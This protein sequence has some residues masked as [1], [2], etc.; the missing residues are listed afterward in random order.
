[1]N[2]KF[3]SVCLYLFQ[4]LWTAPLPSSALLV[5]TY[6]ILDD[7][8]IQN[9]LYSYVNADVLCWQHRRAKIVDRIKA[10]EPDVVCLQELN[11][12]SFEFF[13][14]A[15]EGFEGI[16][17]KKGGSSSHGIGTFCKTH[18]FKGISH[19][20][21]AREGSCVCSTVPLE[22]TLFTTLFLENDRSIT[23]VNTK[24]KWD[25]DAGPE[26]SMGKHVQFILRSIFKTSTVIAGDLNMPPEHPLM[27]NFYLAGL[28]DGHSL[29]NTF[30][31]Y[32]NWSFQKIDY[33]LSTQDLKNVPINAPFAGIPL[34]NEDEP[35]DHLPIAS[36]IIYE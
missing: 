25:K 18:I 4:I 15:L 26:S 2:F 16:F 30:S 22:P 24:I 32:A 12:A 11:K 5:V 28:Y 34:P 19:R 36:L 6:N 35:S 3:L 9:D 14:K 17:A 29:V 27:Q 8:N 23:I 7:D 13:E 31:C 20:A 10:L 33:I 21:I 1:M